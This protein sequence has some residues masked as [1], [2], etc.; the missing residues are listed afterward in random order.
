MTTI[1]VTP[2]EWESPTIGLAGAEFHHLFRVSRLATG[3]SLRVADGT[4]RARRGVI[5]SVQR[6]RAEVRLGEELGAHEPV[7]RVELLV[8]APRKRR[9]EWLVEKTTE[10]G[11]HAVRFLR[12][13][14]GPRSYGAGTFARLHRIARSAAE[15]CERSVV[16]EIKGMHEWSDL[17]RL[18]EASD[19]SLVLD[20]SGPPLASLQRSASVSVLV[21]PEGGWS[22][23]ELSECAELGMVTAGL[24]ARTLRV[25]TAAVVAVATCVLAH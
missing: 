12:S 8:V 18:L 11:V 1:L 15:Q 9:A 7:T 19:L 6:D 23:A 14:R 13:E 3:D 16:P 25:E 21:G 5:E 22:P 20:R 10:L 24:G 17:P 4:G 2:E